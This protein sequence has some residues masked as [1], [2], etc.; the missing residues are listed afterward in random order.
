MQINYFSKNKE[1]G[2]FGNQKVTKSINEF[3]N[4]DF[5]SRLLSIADANCDHGDNHYDVE[6]ITY[7]MY[8]LADDR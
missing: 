2:E 7:D 8:S 1:I 6:D 3:V 4:V 5:L